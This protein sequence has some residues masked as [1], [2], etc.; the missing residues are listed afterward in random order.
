[1]RLKKRIDI[2]R[3]RW[4]HV[5]ARLLWEYCW[6]AALKR[7]S[8]LQGLATA[9]VRGRRGLEIG[10]PSPIFSPH[11]LLPIYDLV[12]AIDNCQFSRHTLWQGEVKEEA[13]SWAR[14][15]TQYIVDGTTLDGRSGPYDFVAASHV[16]EH[17]ANP[18]KALQSWVGLL[19]EGGAL[20][21]IVPHK[22]GTFDC[23]RPDTPFDHLVDDLERDV[24]E[25][26]LSHV[27][28]ILAS[29]EGRLDPGW[30]SAEEMERSV[31]DN[32]HTRRMHHH[33]FGVECLIQMMTFLDLRIA[34]L[35]VRL[36]HHTI[37]IAQ[38]GV[39][40]EPGENRAANERFLR[41]DAPWRMTDPFGRG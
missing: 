31:R 28:E 41:A 38:T 30:E 1:M 18:L 32:L 5:P 17:I 39:R 7:P 6:D 10:G 16:L 29:H 24:S 9:L 14:Q 26:D 37:V 27:A 12:A 13:V 3:H 4:R 40:A 11:G 23:R 2:W 8:G 33:V 35:E 34:G 21:L 20:L 36:P 15:G 22:G 19:P 25:G